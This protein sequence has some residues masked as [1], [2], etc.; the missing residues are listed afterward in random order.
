MVYKMTTRSERKDEHKKL[1]ESRQEK[2]LILVANVQPPT[3]TG[4]NTHKRHE[5]KREIA[6]HLR[7]QGA[8]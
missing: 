4:V 1:M 3:Y 5:H 7:Q 8:A 6:R 2:R